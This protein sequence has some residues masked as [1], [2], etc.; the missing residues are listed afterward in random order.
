M[1]QNERTAVEAGVFLGDGYNDSPNSE[2]RI[3]ELQGDLA[4]QESLLAEAEA[5][6]AAFSDR[7]EA[8]RL[9]INRAGEAE[10][11]APVTGRIWEVLSAGDTNVQRGDPVLRILDC[12]S[13]IVTASVTE[14]VYNSLVIGQAATFRPSGD[15]RNLEATVVR[16]GGSGAET[17]YR[18]LAIAPS[19]RH[20]QRYDVTLSVPGLTAEAD[21]GCAVGRTGRV[22]FERRP[23]DWLRGFGS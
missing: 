6:L 20:L 5:R 9:R 15:D 3:A 18:N 23:M 4:T 2:Q 16:L 22:F 12:G 14:Q 8:E 21:L 17:L 10:L 1:L 7:F 13:V 19:E 11:E